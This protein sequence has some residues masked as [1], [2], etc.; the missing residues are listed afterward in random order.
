VTLAQTGVGELMPRFMAA[1]PLVRVEMQVTN[2]VVDLVEEGVD[3][4]LRVRPTLEA[5][6]SLVI[7]QLGKSRLKLVASAALLAHRGTPAGLDDLAQLD[8]VAMSATEGR[9]SWRLFAPD[10]REHNFVHHPRYAADDML[11]LQKA[12]L[13]GTGIGLLPD[14]LCDDALRS[15]ALV[16]LL[17]DWSLQQ[18]VVHAVFPSRRGLVPA[19]RRFLDFLGEHLQGETFVA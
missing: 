5:S 15:G 13:G 16:Q 3:V 18:G 1:H 11:T 2:R 9:A 8:T 4:A 10:G 17:P 7:K 12:V 6:G 19:V 14:Y